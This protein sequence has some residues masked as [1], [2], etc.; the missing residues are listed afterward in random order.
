MKNLWNSKEAKAYSKDY[1]SLRVYSSRLLGRNPELVLHGGGNTS[2]KGFSKNVFEDS[3]E[4]LFIKGSGWDLISIEKEGFAPVDLNYLVKLAQLG[5]LSDTQ[6][7][8]EQRLATLSTSAPNPSVEAI[9]HALIPYKF[10]DHTHA[11]AVLTITNTT[12][13]RAKIKN[14]YGSDILIVP[15]VMPGFI[16]AKKI[17]K[18]LNTNNNSMELKNVDTE[19]INYFVH[20]SSLTKTAEI[21]EKSKLY[22]PFIK[23]RKLEILNHAFLDSIRKNLRIQL[24]S[25]YFESNKEINIPTSIQDINFLKNNNININDFGNN[26]L[27]ALDSI[28]DRFDYPNEIITINLFR[29]V[30]SESMAEKDKYFNSMV[31]NCALPKKGCWADYGETD[32]IDVEI[33]LFTDIRNQIS[34]NIHIG[35]VSSITEDIISVK[36]K[37]LKIKKQMIL[38]AGTVFNFTY[39]NGAEIAKIDCKDGIDYYEGLGN[40]KNDLLI[41]E[42]QNKCKAFNRLSIY[43]E[44][45]IISTA[46]FHYKLQVIDVID[47]VAI[48]KRVNITKPFV[49]VR[50]GDKVKLDY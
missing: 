3:I 14:I 38:S 4:T 36:L 17:A 37:N 47:S 35:T 30:G 29:L 45:A 41:E 28:Y 23:G 46:P 49:K 6:M 5:K 48:T 15:Y 21:Y 39:G 26:K 7:L 8:T 1:L 34:K 40:D 42:L 25:E 31:I 2:V 22:I 27:V 9:L 13:G 12:N 50:I 20:I 10:V 11:D 33:Q 32:F 16:L 19:I 24:M 44:T 18:Q 43:A